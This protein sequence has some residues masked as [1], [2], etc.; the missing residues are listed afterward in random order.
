M[1]TKWKRRIPV[2]L[3]ATLTM[4]LAVFIMP[5]PA[6]AASAHL[7]ANAETGDLSV[8]SSTQNAAAT[9]GSK[10]DGSY[11]YNISH[12][13]APGFMTWDNTA[14][15]QNHE[16]AAFSF[17]FNLHSRVSSES[18]DLFTL[19]NANGVNHFD[20]FLLANTSTLAWDLLSSNSDTYG[21]AIS[22]DTWYL[23]QGLVYL[24]ASTYTADV[25][26]NGVGQGQIQSTSQ[27]PST[28][29]SLTVG[30]NCCTKTSNRDYDDIDLAV[31]ETPQTFPVVTAG[32][33]PGSSVCPTSAV[34][35]GSLLNGGDIGEGWFDYG[36][37]TS[38]GSTT[39]HQALADNPAGYQTITDTVT[40][41]ATTGWTVHYRSHAK[42]IGGENYGTDVVISCTP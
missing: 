31:G 33:G 24:G 19:R 23:V 8:W 7:T 13:S 39:T 34:L 38:Y 35:G 15:E 27:V 25:W 11:G 22:L 14:I 29:R 21:T 42:N 6:R 2:A 30:P 17:K 5:S 41:L 36:S 3:L 20:M 10:R 16:Y 40:G 4:L 28:V 9:T 12:T 18:V 1:T 32:P 26:V 37:T